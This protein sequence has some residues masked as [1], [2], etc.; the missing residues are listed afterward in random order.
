MEKQSILEEHNKARQMLALGKVSGQ[1]AALNM[2]EMVWD[3]E[4]S[5]IAQRW[6]DQCMPG[7]DHRRNVDRFAVGQNVATTWTFKRIPPSRDSPEFKRHIMGWFDEV[8]KYKWRSRD[9]SPF[10]FRMDTGHY[11]QVQTCYAAECS[12]DIPLAWLGRYI[13]GR[14]WLCILSGP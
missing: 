2:R 10:M 7:H 9:I 6:A 3:E 12:V 4:L 1:P 8:S 14:V 13:P 5:R 11:T